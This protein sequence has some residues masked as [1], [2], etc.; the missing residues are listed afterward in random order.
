[1]LD[2]LEHTSR[3]FFAVTVRAMDQLETSITPAGLRALLVLD[4]EP[5][6][7]LGELAHRIPLS[8]SAASRMVDRL[9][10]AQLLTRSVAAGDRRQVRLTLTPSGRGLVR[11]LVRHRRTTISEV[12]SDMSAVEVE[13]LRRGLDAFSARAVRQDTDRVG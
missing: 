4:E 3:V 11:Q 5:D 10:S 9:V 12:V 6:V 8:Q 7:T 2:D 1:V 13:A